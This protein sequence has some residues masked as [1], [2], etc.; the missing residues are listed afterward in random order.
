MKNNKD[1]LINEFQLDSLLTK[2]QRYFHRIII[3]SNVYC[4][5]CMKMCETGIEVKEII[6]DS[7]NDIVVN[8]ICNVCGGHVTRIIELGENK[9]FYKKANEFRKT[10]LNSY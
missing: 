6:L 3:D 7:Q 5:N 4:S 10:I 1:I 2:E 9:A 8:G